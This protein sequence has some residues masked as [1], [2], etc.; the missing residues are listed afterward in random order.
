MWIGVDLCG[1][2]WIGVGV[3]VCRAFEQLVIVDQNLA[4]ILYNVGESGLF[5]EERWFHLFQGRSCG[6][7][8]I[9]ALYAVFPQSLRC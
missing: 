3:G 5:R 9:S 6:A 8:P 4:K 1:S 2:V 7:F